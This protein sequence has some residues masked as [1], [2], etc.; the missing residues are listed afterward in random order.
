MEKPQKCRAIWLHYTYSNIS[1]YLVQ[2][3]NFST[4]A[5]EDYVARGKRSGILR[6][7]L[8]PPRG[9]SEKLC[10]ESRIPGWAC[11][12]CSLLFFGCFHLF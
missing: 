5:A 4:L 12:I 10:A 2:L 7:V 1:E 11:R 3:E 9:F 6:L 8:S